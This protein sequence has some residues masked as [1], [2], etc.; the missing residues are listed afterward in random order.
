MCKL[1]ILRRLY[2]CIANHSPLIRA[3]KTYNN[4]WSL[5][6]VYVSGLGTITKVNYNYNYND[7]NI[8]VTIMCLINYYGLFQ[9]F[10]WGA[11]SFFSYL[12]IIS[13]KAAYIVYFSDVLTHH[14]RWE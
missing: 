2:F 1:G 13:D 11:F 6:G 12:S 8:I 7:N 3:T 4:V 14:A 9:S 5:G 10:Q